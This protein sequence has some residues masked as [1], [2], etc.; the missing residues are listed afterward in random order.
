MTYR[1][2]GGDGFTENPYFDR[3]EFACKCGCGYAV[4]D[5]KLLE[6]LTTYRSFFNAPMYI[7][8]GARCLTH[9]AKV[10]G[11][12]PK[13]DADHKPIWGTGSQH[14][15]GMAADIVVDGVSPHTV[16]TMLAQGMDAGEGWGGLG[17]Y[18]EFTHVDVREKKSRW[19]GYGVINYVPDENG[20][21]LA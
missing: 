2:N 20:E 21:D 12:A 18:R 15:W 7:T 3:K 10:G 9:N 5:A 16:H 17:E 1:D 8:S 13:L 6:L 19:R 14:L 11:A 4:V